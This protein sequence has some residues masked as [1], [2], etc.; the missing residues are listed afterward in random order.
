MI[1]EAGRGGVLAALGA[2]RSGLCLVVSAVWGEAVMMTASWSGGVMKTASW[3][4]GVVLAA[5]GA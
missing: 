1:I 5:S 4:V 3:G 2:C